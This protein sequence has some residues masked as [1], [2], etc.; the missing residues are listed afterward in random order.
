MKVIINIATHGN[1]RIGKRVVKEL[2]KNSLDKKLIIQVANEKAFKL[3]KR[4]ID[5]DLNR[6]FP[7]KKNGNYEQRIAY[8]ILPKIKS[9]DVV[10]DIHST[11]SESKDA[12]IVTKLN[13]ET[14]NCIKAIQPKNVL[15]MKSTENNA[16]I[17]M[18]KIGLAF[19]YGKDDDKITIRKTTMG[20]KRLLNYL[21]IIDYKFHSKNK[22]INFFEIIDTVPRP[23][24]YKLIKKVK[25][26]KI[27]KRNN[28]YAINKNKKLIAEDDFYPILFG[29]KNYKDIF[30]F[31]GKKYSV[32]S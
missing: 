13:E 19:E 21:K 7:G 26:Y 31:K 8:K 30:G 16:L 24:G 28:N 29:E 6:S 14:L 12:L 22:K 1:E 32:K 15:I 17:S 3:G 11:T 18:A 25:N 9:A 23:K 10:V 4:F 5:Q 27:I 20:I 2:E